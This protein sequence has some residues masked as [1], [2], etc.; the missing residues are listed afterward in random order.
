MSELSNIPSRNY[1]PYIWA[2][3]IIIP[4]VVAILITPGLFPPPQLPFDTK[5]LPLINAFINSA[6]SVLLVTG[7]VLIRRKQ[8]R[9]H[10]IAMLSAYILSALFL[11][12]YVT[13]HL[14]A[15]ETR[16]CELSP[17]PRGLYL[18]LLVSHIVLSVSIVPLA[19][20]SIY[21]SLSGRYEKH[22][23]LARITFP[24]WLYVAVT[25]VLVY[26]FISPCY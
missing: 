2:V 10:R 26:L 7:Y 5:I 12:V 20:F 19:T 9:L 15:E 25:G 21:H 4:V 18:A 14:S 13:Y 23:K 16:W 17:V 22:K 8:Q 24:L 1:T 6:V 11:L 3:S